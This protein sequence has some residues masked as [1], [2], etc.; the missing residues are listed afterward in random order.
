MGPYLNR[1]Q[2]AMVLW[3]NKKSQIQFAQVTRKLIR[4]G[5]FTSS[6]QPVRA[7]GDWLDHSNQNP[8]TLHLDSERGHDACQG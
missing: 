7:I 8:R 4:R 5:T 2:Q 1:L 3:V 6:P